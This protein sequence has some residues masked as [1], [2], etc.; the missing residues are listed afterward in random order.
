MQ[1]YD[2]FKWNYLISHILLYVRLITNGII[3]YK[4]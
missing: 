3:T 2:R 1:V 4:Y